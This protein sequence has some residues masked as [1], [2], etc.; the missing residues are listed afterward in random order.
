MRDTSIQAFENQVQPT[1]S[2]RQAAVRDLLL[3]YPQGLT[4][5]EIAQYL[6]RPI[7]TIT[8]RVHELVN[9]LKVIEDGGIRRCSVTG[10]NAHVWRLKYATL[11]EP[12]KAEPQVSQ[13]RQI[14]QPTLQW[15]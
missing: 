1:L 4:N 13:S 8:P 6:G 7:N 10:S 3:L 11:P 9:K 15:H 2:K 5:S 14:N 12:V